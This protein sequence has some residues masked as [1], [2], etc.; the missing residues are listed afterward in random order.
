[1]VDRTRVSKFLSYVLRHEP[2]AIGLEVD[3]AG[4]ADLDELVAKSRADGRDLDRAL[5]EHVVESDEKDRFAISPD[6]DAI[7]ANYGH[8][9]E[10][11]LGLTPEEPPAELL[12]GTAERFL[13]SIREDGLRPKNRQWVHLNEPTPDGRE[14][15]REVGGRHGTP[16]VLTVQTAETPG[17]FYRSEAGIWLVDAVPPGA[18]TF[19]S[20]EP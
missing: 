13:A 6:G 17:L 9:I 12:H 11:D 5:V 16:V 1:M 2:E 19:P 7:R 4:W 18:I 3:D 10:V 15:A 8:S 14:T 20:S